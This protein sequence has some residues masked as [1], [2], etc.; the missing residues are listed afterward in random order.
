MA[1]CHLLILCGKCPFMEK[2]DFAVVEWSKY[3]DS[4]RVAADNHCGVCKSPL[5]SRLCESLQRVGPSAGE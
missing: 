3:M 5:N 1:K 4:Y 2:L